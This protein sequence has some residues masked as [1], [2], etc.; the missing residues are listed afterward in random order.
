MF[1]ILFFCNMCH[2]CKAAVLFADSDWSER[3]EQ[4]WWW[5]CLSIFLL[6]PSLCARSSFI[7]LSACP[8]RPRGAAEW[9]VAPLTLRAAVTLHLTA[10]HLGCC[11][12]LATRPGF[13]AHGPEAIGK[14]I[15]MPRPNLASCLPG[16]LPSP[17]CLSPPYTPPPPLPCY[18]QMKT[19]QFLLFHTSL[20]VDILLQDKKC[21][22][23]PRGFA[24]LEA[25][26]SVLS[27][28]LHFHQC[29]DWEAERQ[30]LIKFQKRISFLSLYLPR[31]SADRRLHW[32]TIAAHP[33]PPP[34]LWI[35]FSTLEHFGVSQ[36]NNCTTPILPWLI[37]WI[38][39]TWVYVNLI[40]NLS[41]MNAKI[42]FISRTM[43]NVKGITGSPKIKTEI[44]LS[45]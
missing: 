37:L 38:I 41:D 25:D 36:S 9:P 3:T 14:S 35:S 7:A 18:G 22:C 12:H 24:A 20:Y 29:L 8:E 11:G 27:T 21:L 45:S 32:C 43:I 33:T 40:R 39:S 26:V 15:D 2:K 31:R 44:F 5:C 4:R 34:H 28:G 16:W 19:M 23:L 17:F 42:T 6:H 10:L 13:A 1:S 30:Q